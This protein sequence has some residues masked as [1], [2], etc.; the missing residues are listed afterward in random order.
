MRALRYTGKPCEPS[1]QRGSL[2]SWS[3]EVQDSWFRFCGF[4]IP[5]ALIANCHR[6]RKCAAISNA[7]LGLLACR[8]VLR[9][10]L[11]LLKKL[12]STAPVSWSLSKSATAGLKP[13]TQS[14]TARLINYRLIDDSTCKTFCSWYS[15]SDAVGRSD[16]STATHALPKST[17][18]DSAP[19]EN[20]TW[21]APIATI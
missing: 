12:T 10:A 21:R 5:L 2:G 9:N 14:C 19:A 16:G 8:M 13:G 11:T 4:L 6:V 15:A 18:S 20:S 7:I 17:T 1:Y 3:T